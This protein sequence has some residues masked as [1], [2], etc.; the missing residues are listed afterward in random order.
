MKSFLIAMM[1]GL[2]SS[3]GITDAMAEPAERN[4]ILPQERLEIVSRQAAHAFTV[5]LAQTPE[6]QRLGLMNRTTLAPDA[7]ML[8]V[9]P[10]PMPTAFWMHN[11]LIAL[12]MLFIDPQGR[13]IRI[14]ERAEPQTDTPRRSGG[15]VIA[16]L[17]I[18]G[19]RAAALGI[20]AG[21][22]V[23]HRFFRAPVE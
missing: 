4:P 6:Q 14:E 11:T 9:F 13:I 22:R 21:D 23:Q 19:G 18:A 2:F 16:V 3:L 7:G 10:F 12:D 17:E 5:E 8:F 1:I 15:D 20:R